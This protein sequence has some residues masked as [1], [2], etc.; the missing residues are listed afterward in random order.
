M[1]CQSLDHNCEEED[2]QHHNVHKLQQQVTLVLTQM[3]EMKMRMNELER[4]IEIEKSKNEALTVQLASIVHSNNV[5]LLEI[6]HK[7]KNGME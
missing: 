3:R 5:Q 2:N 6:I 1:S 7:K 4:H